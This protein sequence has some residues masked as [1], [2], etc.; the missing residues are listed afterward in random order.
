M[1]DALTFQRLAHL[2]HHRGWPFAARVV[3]RA[4]RHLFACYLAPETVI[5]AGTELGYGGLGVVIHARARL[6][7]DVLVSPGVVVGGRSGLP[8]APVIGDGVCIGA[9]AK[10]LGPIQIG[11]GAF[12]G[13]N[14][15]VIRDVAAG[16]VVAGVPARPV[17]RRLKVLDGAG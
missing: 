11:N 7:R 3:A 10:V 14:A 9:G 1:L 12:I 15:V 16:E 13:A 17:A 6:G 5:G 2:L 8:G 4:T